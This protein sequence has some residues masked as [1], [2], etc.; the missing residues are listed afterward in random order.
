MNN[1]DLFDDDSLTAVIEPLLDFLCERCFTNPESE[2]ILVQN[3]PGDEPH[4]DN[5]AVIEIHSSNGEDT[6]AF[7]RYV[8]A[9]FEQSESD[10]A[11][12]NPNKWPEE[13]PK[14]YPIRF[15]VIKKTW[16]ILD[17]L[18]NNR[19]LVAECADSD[20]DRSGAQRQIR[21]LMDSLKDPA[22]IRVLSPDEIYVFS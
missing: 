20:F 16:A 2:L 1:I 21:M 3:M 9:L 19:F 14:K 13:S 5:R 10:H 7:N 4:D 17:T 6:E 18:V 12:M 8:R 15:L 22:N 11:W